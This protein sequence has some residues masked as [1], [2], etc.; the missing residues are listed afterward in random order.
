MNKKHKN[1]HKHP[2]ATFGEGVALSSFVSG[3]K[4]MFIG[5][6]E[7]QKT[8]EIYFVFINTADGSMIAN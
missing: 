5:K 3:K 2:S 7:R 6:K 8:L 1:C 4:G